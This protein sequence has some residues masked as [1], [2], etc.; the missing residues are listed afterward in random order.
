MSQHEW[1]IALGVLLVS[2]A[3]LI[4]CIRGI[5]AVFRALDQYVDLC[6]RDFQRRKNAERNKE[7]P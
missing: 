6:A 1:L 3:V 2:I 5:N 4:P 7:R